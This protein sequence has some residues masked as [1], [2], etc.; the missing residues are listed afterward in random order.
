M[1]FTQASI[2]I[3]QYAELLYGMGQSVVNGWKSMV[4]DGSSISNGW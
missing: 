3:H 2:S 1:V 4:N